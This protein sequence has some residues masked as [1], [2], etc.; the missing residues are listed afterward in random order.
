MTSRDESVL[1]P[2]AWRSVSLTNQLLA[3]VFRDCA[4][5]TDRNDVADLLGNFRHGAAPKEILWEVLEHR[6]I[7]GASRHAHYRLRNA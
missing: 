5:Y 6:C 4:S 2:G 1:D 7:S 3:D